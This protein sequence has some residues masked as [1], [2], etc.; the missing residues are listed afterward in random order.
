MMQHFVSKVFTEICQNDLE[1]GPGR[2]IQG[3]VRNQSTLQL[4]IFV[5]AL[6]TAATQSQERDDGEICMDK[7]LHTTMKVGDLCTGT[8]DKLKPQTGSLVVFFH[9]LRKI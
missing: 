9:R 1:N 8:L 4:F 6:D 7:A 3:L 2:G 5:L